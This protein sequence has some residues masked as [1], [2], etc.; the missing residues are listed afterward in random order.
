MYFWAP[1]IHNNFNFGNKIVKN[2]QF[3][4]FPIFLH[5][6]NFHHLILL[7]ICCKIDKMIGYWCLNLSNVRDTHGHQYCKVLAK[8]QVYNSA[9]LRKT[10]T[11]EGGA[12]SNASSIEWSDCSFTDTQGNSCVA[13]CSYAHGT[14]TDPVLKP[15]PGRKARKILT[16]A[17][18]SRCLLIA[19]CSMD[20]RESFYVRE[21]G[22]CSSLEFCVE[23][24]HLVH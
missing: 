22:R 3:H 21:Q 5:V 24:E 1:K 6:K 8:A 10:L 9:L 15:Y 16:L 19:Y 17:Q 2:F 20:D 12:N 7:T 14:L 23:R 13:A 4:I 11:C 18:C